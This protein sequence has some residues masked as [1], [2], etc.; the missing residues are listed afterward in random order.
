[1]SINHSGTGSADRAEEGIQ[2]CPDIITRKTGHLLA[3]IDGIVE[4][5]KIDSKI[6]DGKI[7]FYVS[8]TG[9]GIPFGQQPM[10]FSRFFHG[11]SSSSHSFGGMGLGLS[12]TRAYVGLLGG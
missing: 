11:D 10:I 4:I 12:I 8:Y 3:V 7:I 6:E 9:M 5:S 1:M 2:E